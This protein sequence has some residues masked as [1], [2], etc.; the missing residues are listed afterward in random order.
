MTPGSA[1]RRGLAILLLALLPARL[2]AGDSVVVGS[3]SFTESFLLGEMTALLLEEHGMT[4]HRELGLGGT[5]VASGALRSGAVD[6]YPE[7]SG[8]IAETLLDGERLPPAQLRAALERRG[9]QILLPL[10]FDNS[11]AIAVAGPTARRLELR[12]ISDLGAQPQLRAVFSH[13][14]L[15]RSDGW[16]ALREHYG[17]A[18]P[19]RGLEHAL[20]YDALEAGSAELTE[21]YT[22]DGELAGRDIRLLEDDRGFF[23]RYDAVLLAREDLAPTAREALLPLRRALDGERMRELNYRV[24]IGGESVAA[25][26]ADFLADAG[27]IARRSDGDDSLLRRVGAHTLTHLK[28]TVTALALACVV[29]IPAALLL[30]R[31]ARLARALLYVTGLVQTVPALALLALLIPLVGL[32]ELPAILALFL[33]SLLPIVRNTLSGLFS[34]DPLLREV[35]TGM[36]MT[37][38]QR[39]RHVELP[40]AMPTLL[41]GIKTAA[42]VSIGTATLAAFVGA[43]GLGE[44]IITGLNLNNHQMI[45]EGALPAAGLAI[46]AEF[47]FELLERLL[48]PAHLR[49]R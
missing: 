6:L 1:L 25:V 40:L 8:T 41:A 20:A 26:A 2:A 11:Y 15:R 31:H 21:A 44:P 24:A 19:A 10:G 37:P 36:G 35:A 16:Q 34:V 32:G 30:S 42:I 27:H 14:F 17:L 7:Y 3:K 47:L 4:V 18:N 45:L 12:R 43:G 29:A 28:L 13:E 38:L 39:L 22:T 5:L 23:P 33:Y 46:A 48:V 49:D 9:L